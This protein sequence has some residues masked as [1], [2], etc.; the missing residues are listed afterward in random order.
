MEH[1]P[2]KQLTD[3]FESKGYVGK[4]AVEEAKA[5]LERR[6]H[7]EQE[8]V[9]VEQEK[10]KQKTLTMQKSLVLLQAGKCSIIA[11]LILCILVDFGLIDQVR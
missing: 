4:E 9:K 7:L 1:D 6:R 11:I 5:E 10:E 2:L 3:F 8:K